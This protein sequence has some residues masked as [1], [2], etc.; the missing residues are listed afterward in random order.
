MIFNSLPFRFLIICFLLHEAADAQVGIGT[1][2]PAASSMIEVSST[3]KGFLYPRMTNSQMSAISSPAAGLTIYNTDASA[4][5]CYNGTN[6]V[7]KEDH[8]SGFVGMDSPLQL[9]NIRVQMPN[10]FANNSMQIATVSGTIT[11]SGLQESVYRTSA[12]AS[13]GSAASYYTYQRQSYSLGTTFIN[14]YPFDF[15]FHGST[16][17][18]HLMDE[19]NGRA[20]FIIFTV[21]GG[22]LT[23]FISIKR[24][25]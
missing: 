21:G 11:I 18:L 16:Q 9:D 19:T 6:W 14:F 24:I 25:H 22:Y 3:T 7:S 1:N 10:S 13:T 23:N 8:V 20:Y 5:Y 17:F 2:S 15:L 4:L 12:A